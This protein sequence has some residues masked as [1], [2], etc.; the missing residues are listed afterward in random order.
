MSFSRDGK[1]IHYAV[2]R[3]GASNIWEQ[4]LTGGPPRQITTFTD[5]QI[6]LFAW[7]RD[8]KRLAVVRGRQSFD[9]VLMT[10]FK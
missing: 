4:P 8:G 10:N 9:I 1:S 7:S 5:Q 2:V 6:G 3:R